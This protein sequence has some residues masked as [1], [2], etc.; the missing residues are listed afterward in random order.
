MP[1]KG[2]TDPDIAFRSSETELYQ[3]TI[4]IIK[5][6]AAKSLIVFS[7]L[8]LSMMLTTLII[9]IY[10]VLTYGLGSFAFSLG[11]NSDSAL[12]AINMISQAQFV[13]IFII[14]TIITAISTIKLIHKE[15][16]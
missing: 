5:I 11:L 10:L 1:P 9:G 3:H 7:I 2:A 14:M 13:L 8:T 12:V 15:G 16:T 4:S 6:F